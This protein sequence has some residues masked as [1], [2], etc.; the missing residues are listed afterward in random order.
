[1]TTIQVATLTNT[2]AAPYLIAASTTLQL[3]EDVRMHIRS[4][5]DLA[6]EVFPE[7]ADFD[8]MVSQ[9]EREFELRVD[10]HEVRVG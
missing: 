10:F 6:D 8:T 4:S 3:V 9:Y 7:S 5:Y 2:D 1:M